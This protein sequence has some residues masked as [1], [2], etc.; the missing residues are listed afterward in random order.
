MRKLKALSV[1]G[2][3]AATGRICFHSLQ[4]QPF[5]NTTTNQAA[6]SGH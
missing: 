2:A 5:D 1:V 4:Q 3:A 6:A